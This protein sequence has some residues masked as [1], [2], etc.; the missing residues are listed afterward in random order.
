MLPAEVC[1]ADLRVRGYAISNTFSMGLGFATQY[2]ALP[3]YRNMRGLTWVFFA[4]CMAFAFT[5]IYLF[6]SEMEGITLEEVEIVF[7][8]GPGNMV[9]PR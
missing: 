2:S 8:T 6:Y 4:G 3:M 5:V 9:K 7:G 1:S